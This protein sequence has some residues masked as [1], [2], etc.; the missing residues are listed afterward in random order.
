MYAF[1]FHFR[2]S[3][4]YFSFFTNTIPSRYSWRCL[5]L[6][7][8]LCL[9]S[10]FSS[11]C[12]SFTEDTVF[13]SNVDTAWDGITLLLHLFLLTN[14]CILWLSSLIIVSS[15]KK[16]WANRLRIL[17]LSLNDLFLCACWNTAFFPLRP[18]QINT[19][20]SR[21]QFNLTMKYSV[22][23]NL[24]GSLIKFVTHIKTCGYR[25]PCN[26]TLLCQNKPFNSP[27]MKFDH[28]SKVVLDCVNNVPDVAIK[29]EWQSLHLYFCLW[30]GLKP[31][32]T[33]CTDPQLGHFAICAE[34]FS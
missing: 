33:K 13:P 28:V 32:F 34:T 7:P 18:F 14:V 29:T 1:A 22:S 6:I 4:V 11:V 21:I 16:W 17:K 12:I 31:F 27:A 19:C 20:I 23:P 2:I 5:V 8:R 3:N 24:I 10:S 15:D 25:Q 30:C 26:Y 9:I